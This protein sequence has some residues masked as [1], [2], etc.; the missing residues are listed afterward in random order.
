MNED[1]NNT[2]GNGPVD[3]NTLNKWRENRLVNNSSTENKLELTPNLNLDAPELK[4]SP[5]LRNHFTGYGDV[6]DFIDERVKYYK[7]LQESEED[8]AKREKREKRGMTLASIGDMLGSFHNAYAYAKGE[9]PM[10]LPS[11]TERMKARYE[12]AK[13]KRDENSDKIFYYLL[14][15][16]KLMDE[17]HTRDLQDKNF[18]LNVK[19]EERNDR[20]Q[21]AQNALYEARIG[22]YKAVEE[23]NVEMTAYYRAKTHYLE[24]GYDLEKAES[25]ARVEADRAR[26][27]ASNA[28]AAVNRERAKSIR[29]NRNS[30]G[31]SRNGTQEYEYVTETEK[32]DDLGR[33]TTTVTRKRKN[34]VKKKSSNQSNGGKWA[35]SLTLK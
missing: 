11:L 6:N 4:V 23:K 12:N 35:S 28:S 2:V 26:A 13:A 32:T 14:Q 15:R 3:G 20:R 16:E 10:E 9:K 30:R 24:L 22:Y 29:N 17:K 25:M 27:E 8:R 7:S 21:E 19:K 31:S 1:K 34:P 18:E 33:K 5:E